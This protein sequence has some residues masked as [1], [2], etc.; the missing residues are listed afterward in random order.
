[1]NMRCRSGT[2][3]RGA[4]IQTRHWDDNAPGIERR[5]ALGAGL[6]CQVQPD[7][8]SPRAHPPMHSWTH[9]R[10]GEWLEPSSWGGEGR[11]RE[12]SEV[13]SLE[14]FASSIMAGTETMASSIERRDM[15]RRSVG[16]DKRSMAVEAEKP[17]K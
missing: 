17:G 8:R 5:Q 16:I 4:M 3:T 11:G 14:A 10:G 1:M 7:R 15:Q 6:V 9:S 12:L 2:Q 13:A